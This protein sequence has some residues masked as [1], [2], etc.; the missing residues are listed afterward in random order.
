MNIQK[1]TMFKQ[2]TKQEAM[3]V[4]LNPITGCTHISPGCKNCY[5]ERLT[6]KYKDL[7]KSDKYSQGF[8]K[9]VLHEKALDAPL[10]RKKSETY[11]VGSMADIF[12]TD[13]PDDFLVQIHKVFER[14]PQHIFQ[15]LTKRSGRMKQLYTTGCLREFVKLEN[16]WLGV[17]VE[18]KKYGFPRMDDLKSIPVNT[19]FI[20]CEPLLEDLGPIDL[21]GIHWLPCGGESG[22]G[23]RDVDVD[24]FRSLRDQCIEQ[25]VPFFFKQYS[26]L[27]PRNQLLDGRTWFERPPVPNK[28]S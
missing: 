22:K 7:W 19:R 2:K 3:G 18:N 11:F 10:K 9:V 13:V 1:N 12:H 5:A 24:W 15:V 17:S 6:N 20:M 25:R 14:C 23:F 4:A 8:S 26:G 28:G 16:L 21:S 27:K